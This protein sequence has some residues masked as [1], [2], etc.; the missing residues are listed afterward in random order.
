MFKNKTAPY[1]YT[2]S[3]EDLIF[4]E[5]A[6]EKDVISVKKNFNNYLQVKINFKSLKKISKITFTCTNINLLIK[7]CLTVY[8]V[9]FISM[10]I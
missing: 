7:K 10:N 1:F 5:T 6:K 9:N 3:K 2:I 4:L 8:T